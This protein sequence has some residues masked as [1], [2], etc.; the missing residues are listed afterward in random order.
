MK[1][2]VTQPTVEVSYSDNHISSCE[3]TSLAK[4]VAQIGI[5]TQEATTAIVRLSEL[6]A[7]IEVLEEEMSDIR[8]I[9]DEKT[10]S[11]KQKDDLEIFNRIEENP[12]LPGFIDLD[13]EAFL[14]QRTIWD[15][16][17]D[18]HGK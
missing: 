4:T 10:E 5:S 6:L 11:P 17:E 1:I 14:N 8:S 7:R 13:S 15:F 12:F 16:K 18:W 2:E 9:L 3:L